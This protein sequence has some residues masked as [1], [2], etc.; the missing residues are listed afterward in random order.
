MYAH[1]ECM[2]IQT[3]VERSKVD[4]LGRHVLHSQKP[5]PGWNSF[6]CRAGCDQHIATACMRD[7]S[8][9]DHG[10]PLTTSELLG[11][12]NAVRNGRTNLE[13]PLIV[14]CSAG[15]GRTGTYI[16]IDRL[17]EQCFDLVPNLDVDPIVS[18]MRLARNFMVQTEIQYIFIYRAVFDAVTELYA[19]ETAAAAQREADN[20][21]SL[22]ASKMATLKRAE[23]AQRAAKQ[24]EELERQQIEEA[25]LAFERE[26]QAQLAAKKAEEDLAHRAVTEVPPGAACHSHRAHP[27]CRHLPQVNFRID[28]CVKCGPPPKDHLESTEFTDRVSLWVSFSAECGTTVC[29]SVLPHLRHAVSFAIQVKIL[30]P[31]KQSTIVQSDFSYIWI[32]FLRHTTSHHVRS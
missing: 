2:C 1:S 14:H 17:L 21:N 4:T 16:A 22:P 13:K 25:R 19:T 18:D 8:W 24:Q 7:R 12:R 6:L 15:V 31:R 9:P 5:C 23:A 28:L 20:V 32:F 30:I 11:F 10:A 26:Q 29:C 3:D 27:A